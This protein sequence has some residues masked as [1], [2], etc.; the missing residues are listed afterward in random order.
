[1]SFEKMAYPVLGAGLGYR[2]HLAA[3][4]VG[5]AHSSEWVELIG[6]HF[7]P[8]GAP[9][10]RNRLREIVQTL[11]CVVHALNMSIAA[12]ESEDVGYIAELRQVANAVGA[13]WVSDH[14]A[15][16]RTSLVDLGGFFVPYRSRD[17]AVAIANK[18]ARIQDTL[19][20]L[21]LLENVAT[22]LD[23][24]GDLSE[25]DFINTV[26]PDQHVLRVPKLWHRS[27]FLFAA[28]R[29]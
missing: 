7:I 26:R 19:E 24:G 29:S 3:Y 1:M 11:P 22:I 23:P 5:R 15:L 20:R 18:A 17:V 12:Q 8:A 6:D 10:A 28:A 14:L 9:I 4:L 25:P 2:Q 21:L 27:L 16:S 13:P